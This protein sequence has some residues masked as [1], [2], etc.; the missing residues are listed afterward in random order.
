MVK[1]PQDPL[2][3]AFTDAAGRLAYLEQQLD[4]NEKDLYQEFRDQQKKER[5]DLNLKIERK[6]VELNEAREKSPHPVKTYD[7]PHKIKDPKCRRIA[8][9]LNDL[10]RDLA[11]QSDHQ[12][13]QRTDTLENLYEQQAKRHHKERPTQQFDKAA[14]ETAQAEK[15]LTRAFERVAA[16]DKDRPH[17]RDDERD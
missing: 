8:L 4:G 2:Y 9:Q 3:P 14:K 6:R 17:E 10:H 13:K 12:R 1:L 5:D 11:Q 16:E 7:P 15:A